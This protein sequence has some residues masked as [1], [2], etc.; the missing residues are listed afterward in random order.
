MRADRQRGGAA[1]RGDVGPGESFRL[2]NKDAPEIPSALRKEREN[3]GF[4]G[5]A[6]GSPQRPGVHNLGPWLSFPVTTQ[7]QCPDPK[8]L[9]QNHSH[10]GLDPDSSS[11]GAFPENSI[12]ELGGWCSKS[13][14]FPKFADMRFLGNRKWQEDP[15]A[16]IPKAWAKLK[17]DLSTNDATGHK[18]EGQGCVSA[19]GAGCEPLLGTGEDCPCTRASGALV[20]GPDIQ[21]PEEEYTSPESEIKSGTHILCK[22]T[23]LKAGIKKGFGIIILESLI[24]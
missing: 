6:L 8:V 10:T 22:C 20:K 1:G 16:W 2:A 17:P 13:T 11:P 14:L 3:A 7:H 23:L 5:W 12:T 24:V 21:V 9:F 15:C 4:D 19:C 18:E